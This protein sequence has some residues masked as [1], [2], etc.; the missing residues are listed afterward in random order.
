MGS[1]QLT[2]VGQ[3]WAVLGYRVSTRDQARSLASGV[4]GRNLKATLLQLNDF[5]GPLDGCETGETTQARQQRGATPIAC[6]GAWHCFLWGMIVPI[7]PLLLA[8]FC[9]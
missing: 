7:S 4:C 6:M 1:V 2:G 5:T 9:P 8:S 3:G